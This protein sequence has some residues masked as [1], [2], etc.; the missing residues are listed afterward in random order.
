MLNI[1]VTIQ[2][3]AQIFHQEETSSSSINELIDFIKGEHQKKNTVQL[4][5]DIGIQRYW[6]LLLKTGSG[7]HNV[8]DCINTICYCLSLL[9]QSPSTNSFEILYSK[10]LV[11]TIIDSIKPLHIKLDEEEIY[12]G[13]QIISTL[14]QSTLSASRV[15]EE[16]NFGSFLTSLLANRQTT[17]KIVD[18]VVTIICQLSFARNRQGHDLTDMV[19]NWTIVEWGRVFEVLKTGDQTEQILQFLVFDTRTIAPIVIE[20]MEYFMKL[21]LMD[22]VMKTSKER[23]LVSVVCRSI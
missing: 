19:K 11:Q 18:C 16:T 8:K 23:V 6:I 5:V 12:N 20:C 21:G 15:T 17:L 10:V 2:R 7:T 13:L 4:L 1:K 22:V 14:M 9:V 3:I